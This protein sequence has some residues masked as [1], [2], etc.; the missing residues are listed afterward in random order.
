[1]TDV[2]GHATGPSATP[3]VGVGRSPLPVY[4]ATLFTSAF[5]L[6]WVQPLIAKMLLPLIGGAPAVWN[7][8]MM[9]FQLVLL[10]GYLYAHMLSRRVPAALQPWIHGVV[11]LAAFA[12]LP[13]AIRA[14]ELPPAEASPIAWLVGRLAL[15]VGLPFFALSA[16]APLLQSWFARSGHD[17]A[18]DPYFLY[19]ASNLGSLLALL[20]FPL[21]L[22]PW[23][24]LG[25]Q[26]QV[27]MLLYAGLA[28]LVAG[29][30]VL[31]RPAALPAVPVRDAPGAPRAAWPD[32]LVWIALASVPSSLL[33]GVTTF[34]ATDVASAPL[35][36]VIP[37]ALYLLSFV[38]V[39]ARRPVVSLAWSMDGQAIAI[40][41]LALLYVFNAARPYFPLPASPLGLV[42]IVHFATFFFTA[43]VCHGALARRRPQASELTDFYLCLSIGGALGGVFNALLAPVLFS[44]TY[45]YQ[46]ALVLGCLLRRAATSAPKMPRLTYRHAALTVLAVAAVFGLVAGAGAM[47]GTLYQERSF[48]GV[49]R[50][51]RD[52]NAPKLDLVHGVILHGAELTDP[53]RWREELGYYHAVGPAGQFFSALRAVRPEPLRIAV[54]GLGTGTLACYARPDEAWT[55]YEI[56]P[57]V[58]RIARDTRFF[59]YLER[60]GA[61]ARIV[62][63]DARLSLQAGPGRHYDV[64]VLDAFSSD[65][66]PIHLLT[67]EALRV[68]VDQMADAGVLVLHISNQHLK[69]WPMLHALA[70]EL[71]LAD[72]H[73][74]F[75]PTPEET[76]KFALGSE[77]VVL[78]R[79]DADLAFLDAEPRWSRQPPARSMRP[80][81]DDFSN[82]VSVMEW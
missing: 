14:G 41:G 75:L 59:H 16:S 44:S 80:W 40:I 31:A 69:L 27:W 3:A 45:E 42:M 73:Q 74:L 37:L 79:R 23:L 39:F 9:F 10:A 71:G 49:H 62:L 18:A 36:W 64:L 77:Y 33:L 48:F 13:F 70:G 68:Y 55:F 60:C 26:S 25:T 47:Q 4:A 35:L 1:M 30:A 54:A 19:G 8:A 61:K 82:I 46:L 20:A 58:E 22:E 65:A 38:V 51:V 17:G 43:L 67:R 66:I 63:G 7:T 81:S 78:A 52:A 56:D 53:A 5:L 21:V 57:A 12:I 50:V 11:V 2:P 15:Y 72:R 28:V 32:R 34:V 24:T 29:C 76:E 6:F